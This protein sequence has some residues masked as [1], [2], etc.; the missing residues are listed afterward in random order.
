MWLLFIL[1]FYIPSSACATEQKNTVYASAGNI[2]YVL[3]GRRATQLTHSEHDRSPILSPNKKSIV[4]IRAGT[5][6]IPKPC[7][8]FA[9]TSTTYGE[10]IW[11]IDIKHKKERLLV[12][13]D[14]SCKQPKKMIVAPHQLTFSPDSQTLY[15]LTS[16]WATSGAVHAV[17]IVDGQQ[18]YILPANSLKII[19][20]GEYKGDLILN[21]HRYFIGGGSYDWYWLFTPDGRTEVGPLGE[22]PSIL[23]NIE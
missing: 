6:I 17:S 16:A 20:S 11:I 2:Y 14:F 15:F 4:F 18:H 13:N 9:N 23:N 10:Q 5:N 12:N 1:L 8:D 19:L 3:N 7:R 21:Q 22:E